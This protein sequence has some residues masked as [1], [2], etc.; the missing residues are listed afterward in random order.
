MIYKLRRELRDHVIFYVIFIP[1]IYYVL[2]DIIFIA[3]HRV[4]MKSLN[5]LIMLR[6]DDVVSL[7]NQKKINK[8]S[9]CRLGSISALNF[10]M[11]N[12]GYMSQNFNPIS[13]F[14]LVAVVVSFFLSVF[15]MCSCKYVLYHD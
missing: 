3:L 6:H 8:I 1:N 14:R 2:C 10:D 9:L 15:R 12:N 11:M 5:L 4:Q 13:I 7:E